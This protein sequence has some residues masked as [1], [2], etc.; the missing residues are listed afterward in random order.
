MHEDASL[1]TSRRSKHCYDNLFSTM[2][3]AKGNLSHMEKY[4]S[5]RLLLLR[6]RAR[7]QARTRRVSFIFSQ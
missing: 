7:K 3:H 4:G 6:V 5:E 2:R 1:D